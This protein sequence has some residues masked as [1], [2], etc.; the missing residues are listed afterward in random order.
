MEAFSFYQELS[1]KVASLPALKYMKIWVLTEY[2]GVHAQSPDWTMFPF[3]GP[4]WNEADRK[5]KEEL[6]KAEQ[7][8]AKM[9]EH[10][11][12][13]C[14]C[15]ALKNPPWGGYSIEEQIL[16]EAKQRKKSYRQAE[17][18]DVRKS[19][20]SYRYANNALNGEIVIHEPFIDEL[21]T[22]SDVKSVCGHAI[23]PWLTSSRVKDGSLSQSSSKIEDTAIDMLESVSL[24]DPTHSRK[25]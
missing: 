6:K 7:L 19:R 14:Y 18:Q 17:S 16:H 1:G 9:K 21:F 23:Q 24:L 22:A 4:T 3:K 8:K 20:Y 12:S 10:D 25:R 15:I 2:W 11:Y 5:A 13:E